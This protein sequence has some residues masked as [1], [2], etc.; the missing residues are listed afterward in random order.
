[1]GVCVM[2]FP[3]SGRAVS[4]ACAAAGLALSLGVVPS[5]WATG[6][7]LVLDTRTG[8]NDGQ[9]GIVL[10]NAPLDSRPIAEPQPFAAP[11]QLQSGGQPPL[12][13]SPYIEVPA[14]GGGRGRRGGDTG[15]GSVPRPVYR[16]PGGTGE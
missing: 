6:K 11:V 13:V 15:T 2:G 5:A 1:M 7:P 16:M 4:A 3:F 12:I 9:T 8:I 10:Q 14:A